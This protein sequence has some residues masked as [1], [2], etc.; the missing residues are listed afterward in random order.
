MAEHTVVFAGVPALQGRNTG[1][2]TLPRFRVTDGTGT[3]RDGTG[4]TDGTR[5]GLW[6]QEQEWPV[7]PL[8]VLLLALRALI[9][10]LLA[11][12][13]LLVLLLAYG[14]YSPVMALRALLSSYGP[15]GLI[16]Q[17]WPYGLIVQ[18]WPVGPVTVLLGPVG[19]YISTVRARRAILVLLCP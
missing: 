1:Y 14:P 11:L 17:L 15:T 4:R 16:V 18:L 12:R 8:V 6:A 13:A 3:G 9:V 10:L 2:P 5:P 7:G 19:P